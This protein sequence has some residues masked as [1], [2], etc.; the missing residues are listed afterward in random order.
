ME[1]TKFI[2]TLEEI[3]QTQ[4]E[5]ITALKEKPKQQLSQKPNSIT[6][7]ILEVVDHMNKATELYL[8]QIETKIDKLKLLNK[9]RFK[10]TWLA[11]K[12]TKSL[13]PTPEG[14]INN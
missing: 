8:D 5:F 14:E 2:E 7:S 1:S 12:F 3:N 13:A 10:K 4:R 9:T 6:W 11:A